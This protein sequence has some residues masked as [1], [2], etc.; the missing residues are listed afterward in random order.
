MKLTV[1]NVEN[2]KATATRQEILDRDGLYFIVQPSG[3]KSWAL[4]SG[5][6]WRKRWA[7]LWSGHGS[8]SFLLSRSATTSPCAATTEC[9]WPGRRN[10]GCRSDLRA[11]R[12][13]M[14]PCLSSLFSK[15]HS[16]KKLNDSRRLW[17][18]IARFE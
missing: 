17:V 14:I 8:K 2:W 16:P 11:Q 15:L 6:T 18:G 10:T 5:L 13:G 3:V 12:A 1:L 9:R 4:R 7:W